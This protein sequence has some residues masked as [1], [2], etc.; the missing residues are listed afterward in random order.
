MD[1]TT[2]Y[3]RIRHMSKRQLERDLTALGCKTRYM[4]APVMRDVLRSFYRDGKVT[5]EFIIQQADKYVGKSD[6]TRGTRHD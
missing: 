3:T 4:T 2:V 5:G 1:S 6:V